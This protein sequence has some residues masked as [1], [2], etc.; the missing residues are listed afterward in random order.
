MRSKG[1]NG[2][3]SRAR[4]NRAS[5]L[6]LGFGLAVAFA[7]APAGLPAQAVP[8]ATYDPRGT[9]QLMPKGQP[10][11]PERPVAL[12]V[13]PDG[14]IHIADE[15]GLVF[16]YN[17]D[18]TYA[19]AY[20]E[21][22]LERPAAVAISSTGE[23]YVLDGSRHRVT[24]F[25]P[26]G[27]PLRMIAAKG[28][29]GGQLSKPLDLALGP[30]GYL[31]ILDA[32]LKGI[33]VF[34]WDGVFVREIP[35]GN[36]VNEPL[37]LTV[38]LDGTIY[39]ADGRTA[40]Q[41]FAFAP[42]PEHSWTTQGERTVAGRLSF[43]A[44]QFRKPTA[45]AVN[46]LGTVLVLDRESGRVF[47]ANPYDGADAPPHGLVY[48]GLGR[49]R[50]SFQEATDIAFAGREAALILDGQLRKIERIELATE[51]GLSPRPRFDYAIRVS[52]VQRGLPRPLLDIEYRNEDEALMLVQ[53]DDREVSLVAAQPVVQET[54]YGDSVRIFMPDP[55]T[56]RQVLSGDIRE[57]AAGIISDTAVLLLDSRH[58]R[59]SVFAA[60]TGALLGS[61]G[62]NYRD[63][64]RLREPRDM[65]VLA[66]GRIV[67]ADTRNDRITIF[68]ADL[69]SLVGTYPV[70]RPVGVAV[71]P[72]GD[73]HVW[74]ENGNAGRLDMTEQAVEPLDDRLLPGPVLDMVFD[75]AGNL[76]ILDGATERVTI[77][78]AALEGIMVQ[79][80]DEDGLDRPN[81][82]DVDRDGNIYVSDAGAERT[83]IH[84]WDVRIE[85]LAGFEI[86]FTADAALL[87]WTGGSSSFVRGFEIQGAAHADGPY[88]AL[89]V[90][91]ASPYELRA[92]RVVGHPSRYVRVAPILVTGVR[93]RST[94]AL[95][96]T[97]LNVA[98]AHR[99]G[100][101][102]AA[103][104][105]ARSAVDL[106][107]R[108]VIETS[109]EVRGKIMRLAFASAYELGDYPVAIEWAR[110]AAEIPMPREELTE[111]AFRLAEIYLE[112]GSP[113]E[114]SQQILRLVGE[115]PRPEYFADARVVDQSFQIYRG[116]RDAGYPQD[117]LDFMRL[118]T[119]SIPSSVPEIVETYEDSLAV[120]STRIRLG[121]GL[122]AWQDANFAQAVEF[123]E[124]VLPQGGLTVEQRVVALQVLA[125]AY[126]A[127][128]RRTEAED[129]FREIFNVRPEFDLGR[130]ISRLRS[131]YGLTL[132]N[133]DM[134]RF[135]E[136]IRPGT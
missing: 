103:L 12:A 124:G 135:F 53:D 42:F 66:D 127:F 25:G 75:Q 57:V 46:E 45:L 51:A 11:A 16:I 19:G 87:S 134:E 8:G 58:D 74:D 97:Y 33:Q 115:N 96:L 104:S 105:E 118:Y 28:N 5:S 123:F 1:L 112:R 76:F 15:R 60:E 132:Y 126:Y 68:S 26:G 64:R 120:F 4:M 86:D 52:R 92:D 82:I 117:A 30:S 55:S 77:V 6:R 89:A 35:L 85:P 90:T 44:A 107:D 18:G 79:L 83:A 17:E 84:R 47:R 88:T 34:S 36:E 10:G 129:Q 39:V 62:D 119:Q 116:L 2:I 130:E 69:A 93:G 21:D 48:G 108:G 111:F 31:Y 29:R 9:F 40:S 43:P 109:P 37:S 38:G 136:T 24:V 72:G 95:P 122:E 22:V 61:F 67:I 27:Q 99:G 102:E 91:E 32:D 121:P 54:V 13:A 98:L 41:I 94:R 3:D 80:G 73:I 7:A 78:D 20:G 59:L 106:M 49:G 14:G 56:F 50:G 110:R 113:R 100:Q 114:A 70:P 128:G 101:H 81:R 125:C 65:A 131:L 23:R 71:S 133:S 63:D